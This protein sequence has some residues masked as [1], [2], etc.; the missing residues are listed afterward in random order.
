MEL[1]VYVSTDLNIKLV[2]CAVCF[3][4]TSVCVGYTSCQPYVSKA[5]LDHSIYLLLRDCLQAGRLIPQPE[6]PWS[7][8]VD[9]KCGGVRGC[10]TV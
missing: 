4:Y 1:A 3:G 9:D 6:F 7:A 5:L 2:L 8:A 10:G